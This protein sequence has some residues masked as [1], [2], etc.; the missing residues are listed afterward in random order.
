MKELVATT[1]KESGA[2]KSCK[3]FQ[4]LMKAAS[5]FELRL[6]FSRFLGYCGAA[7]KPDLQRKFVR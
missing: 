4:K 1:L 5:V 3:S 2:R 6:N 7:L